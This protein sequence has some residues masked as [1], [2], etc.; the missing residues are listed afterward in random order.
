M[1]RFLPSPT[2]TSLHHV[3]V[4]DEHVHNGICD[5]CQEKL[6]TRLAHAKRGSWQS[7]GWS[8]CTTLPRSPSINVYAWWHKHYDLPRLSCRP[9]ESSEPNYGKTAGAHQNV[10]STSFVQFSWPHLVGCR[11]L[12][13]FVLVP[14]S[15][16]IT[17]NLKYNT[18]KQRF[19]WHHM[20]QKLHNKLQLSA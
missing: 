17:H 12:C 6:Q 4:A 11:S 3:E 9:L 16:P 18:N 10:C 15:I 14:G 1:R 8:S 20:I 7:Y 2:N 5:S 19:L 13:L